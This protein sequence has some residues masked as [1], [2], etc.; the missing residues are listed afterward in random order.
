MFIVFGQCKSFNKEMETQEVFRNKCLCPK[1]DK[2]TANTSQKTNGGKQGDWLAGGTDRRTVLV[3]GLAAGPS[4]RGCSAA[5][6]LV[7][8]GCCLSGKS[9]PALQRQDGYGDP[10]SA[11]ALVTQV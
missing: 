1:L 6:F 9:S 11:K 10:P 4:S 7:Q 8:G 5:F 3:L 2:K